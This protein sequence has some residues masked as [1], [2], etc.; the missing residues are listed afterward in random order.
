MAK[1]SYKK[2][3]QNEAEFILPEECLEYKTPMI[4]KIIKTDHSS[5]SAE[6]TDDEIEEEAVRLLSDTCDSRDTD[7]C[8]DTC[9]ES[10][11]ESM[12]Q[13]CSDTGTQYCSKDTDTEDI[14]SNY[15]MSVQYP[16]TLQEEDC[17]W[18]ELEK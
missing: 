11:S 7:T 1:Y 9:T 12:L 3:S 13:S 6:H 14:I 18:G 2:L 15:Q 8:T 10:C 16:L 4:K 17:D 5:K